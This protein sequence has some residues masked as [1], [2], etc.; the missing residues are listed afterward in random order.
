YL[1]TNLRESLLLAIA[2]IALLMLVLFRTMKMVIISLL[3]NIIPLLIT[4]GIMGFV[5]INLKPSTILIFS[6][7]FGIAS[8]QTLYF[9]TKYRHEQKTKNWD[10]SKLT[11]ITLKESG[12]GMIYT[13]II[14][15]FGFGIFAASNFG[16]TVSLGILI[17]ITLL[18]AVISN[19]ILLPSLLLSLEKSI[20]KKA[21]SDLKS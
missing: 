10:I 17:S 2:L 9:L 15:F 20:H 6:I 14:L 12:L 11:S 18:V 16:G 8:D 13:A 5:G 1:F 3:P 21:A 4:A 7:A 19:L